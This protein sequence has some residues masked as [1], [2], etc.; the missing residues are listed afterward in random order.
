MRERRLNVCSPSV[1][2]ASYLYSDT[3]V[4][5]LIKVCTSSARWHACEAITGLHITQVTHR[6]AQAVFCAR[7]D[8]HVAQ[9]VAGVEFDAGQL[10]AACGPSPPGQTP[11]AS[12]RGVDERSSGR[13][14][15]WL[16]LRRRWAGVGDFDGAVHGAVVSSAPA[17]GWRVAG[18]LGKRW[19]YAGER[20]AGCVEAAI[21]TPAGA[22]FGRATEEIVRGTSSGALCAPGGCSSAA[23]GGRAETRQGGRGGEGCHAGW[24]RASGARDE[25][26]NGGQGLRD[27]CGGGRD[28]PLTRRAD[29]SGGYGRGGQGGAGAPEERPGQRVAAGAVQS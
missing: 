28:A 8:T 7:A 20:C 10:R 24:G 6:I 26:L 19:C 3:R 25:G 9:Q 12:E 5:Q 1:R 17:L 13:L 2:C 11:S 4:N 16:R 23:R 29:G 15:V 27:G 21:G 18:C 22:A 14:R